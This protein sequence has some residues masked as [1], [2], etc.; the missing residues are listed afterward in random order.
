MDF[1]VFVW[2]GVRFLI[3]AALIVAVAY[4][5]ILLMLRKHLALLDDPANLLRHGVIVRRCDALDSVAE[6]IGRYRGSDIYRY[7]TFKGMRYDFERVVPAPR[8]FQ[9][10]PKELFVEP[11]I[12]YVAQA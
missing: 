5:P 6:I 12:V 2:E 10:G 1:G 11:G 8:L 7:V 9:V 3:T 4:L